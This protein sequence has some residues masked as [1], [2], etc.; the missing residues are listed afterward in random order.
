MTPAR[1]SLC[2]L[3]LAA[4]VVA[5]A[6]APAA[7]RRARAAVERFVRPPYL[8]AGDTVALVAPARKLPGTC[9]TARIRERFAEWGLYA[10]FGV[11]A[12][13]RDEPYFSAPDSLRAADL[14]AAVDDP[15]VK[16]IIA[17]RGGYGSARL[18]PMLDLEPLRRHP[19]WLVG[20][21]DITALHL[22]LRRLGVESIHGTMPSRFTF[23]AEDPSAEAL[24]QALFGELTGLEAP[25]HPLDR[26]GTARG[27]VV[28]GNLTLLSAAAGTPEALCPE[29]PAILFIEEVG[30]FAYRLDR[31][32][33]H[34]VRSGTLR[35]VTGVVV[36]HLTDIGGLRKFGVAEP[37]EALAEVLRPLGIPVAFGFPAGHDTPNFP[38]YLGRRAT[39]TV[40]DREA[41]L[42][43]DSAP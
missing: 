17:C 4:S 42:I 28:G 22:V 10:K 9:D 3:M 32:M 8:Q 39:L 14:Q 18:L 6:A 13:D 16:A 38:L 2:L 31:M 24:R 27:R 11:H 41:R 29:A 30:E 26:E 7:K 36:G 21:S 23:D 20:F 15:S 40:D 37:A 35:H 19:K 1:L 12:C 33:R 34:L 43:F 5:Q 25:H